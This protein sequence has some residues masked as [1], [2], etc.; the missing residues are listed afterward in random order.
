[1]LYL[2]HQ[3][4]NI[5]FWRVKKMKRYEIKYNLINIVEHKSVKTGYM[6]INAKNQVEAEKSFLG[7]EDIG[8]CRYYM[9]KIK[10]R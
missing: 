9:S 2:L 10:E 1:M 8:N 7:L 4:N 5:N 3:I 6:Y